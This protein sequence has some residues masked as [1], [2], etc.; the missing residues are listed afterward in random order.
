MFEFVEMQLGN[1][2][3]YIETGKMAKQANGAALVRY[4]S[5]VVLVAATAAKEPTEDSDMVPLTVDYRERSYAIGKIPGVYGR[6]EP[7]PGTNETLISRLVDHCI[8]PLFPKN[9]N[10]EVQVLAT[11]FS[12]DQ[13]HMPDTLALIGASAA[14][15]LSDIPFA[16]PVAAVVVGRINGQLIVNPTYDELDHSDLE[17][18]VSGNSNAVMSVEGGAKEITEDEIIEAIE[19]AHLKIKGITKL[20]EDLLARGARP[21]RVFVPKVPSEEL[22]AKMRELAT[23]KIRESIGMAD[24][25]QRASYLEDLQEDVLSELGPD[26]VEHEKDAI[27]ILTQIE[28]EQMRQA[29][30]NE[31]RRIDGRGVKDI[32]LITAEVGVLPRTHGSALFTRGQTQVLCVVTLGTTSDEEVIFDLEGESTKAFMLHYNF[33]P[34]SVGEVRRIGG[35]GR[36]EIG[37]G[38]LAERAILPAM[39]AKEEFPYTVRVVSEILESNSSSSM[40]TVCGTSLALMDAGVLIK[41]P[42]AG[43]GVGLIKEGDKEVILTDMLGDEDHLGD[44][45]FKVAGTRVGITAVQLDI[46]IEGISID[47]MRQAIHQAKEARMIILDKMDEVISQP[48]PELSSYAPRLITIKINP[49]KIRDIIGPGGKMIRKI[50]AESGAAINIEDDG[51][52]EIAAVNI[53]SL[54]IATEMVNFLTAEAEVGKSY[55]GKVTRITNFGAFVEFLPGQEGLVHISELADGYVRKVEDVVKEGDEVTVKV[56][57][58]DEQGRV[59]L[60]MRTIPKEDRVKSERPKTERSDQS[61][62]KPPR[63]PKSRYRY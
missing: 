5:T 18:F 3:L 6:R 17:L 47:L 24:K 22:D 38:A 41:K 33:P 15:C 62:R 32:R 50:Q 20:Q 46:K 63:L 42:V 23:G 27:Q 57:E 56:L 16:G 8:R 37:H 61:H 10:Y 36:R 1:E 14:L 35:P 7:R 39:P 26:Y 52:V 60:S 19:F 59:E 31:G 11:A 48:R 58:R 53:K 12:S 30:L 21:K 49:D 25:Q 43:V 29:I 54:E 45:D 44:M 40:A 34:Y 28:R 51:S 55:K 13:E 9:Y 4:G 2:K